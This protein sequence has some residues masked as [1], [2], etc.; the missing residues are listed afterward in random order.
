MLGMASTWTL[1]RAVQLLSQQ[2]K[3]CVSHSRCVVS[4]V[5]QHKQ[6]RGLKLSLLPVK[7]SRQ[8]LLLLSPVSFGSGN[9]SYPQRRWQ[10]SPPSPSPLLRRV[11][12]S[13]TSLHRR[14]RREGGL[15]RRY[16]KHPS[17]A[18]ISYDSCHAYSRTLPPVG[19]LSN[20]IVSAPTPPSRANTRRRGSLSMSISASFSCCWS[21]C[22]FSFA[23]LQALVS[24]C[25]RLLPHVS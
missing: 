17:E 10:A 22:R 25:S 9:H 3:G 5:I 8:W 24:P 4:S 11:V 1:T 16:T 12:S 20:L 6:A 23:A 15:R 18:I 21:T 13:R 14:R 2:L 19:P 7:P